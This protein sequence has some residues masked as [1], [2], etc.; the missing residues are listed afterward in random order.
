MGIHYSPRTVTDGLVLAFDTGNDKSYK[1]VPT[2]NIAP[3]ISTHG[4]SEFTLPSLPNGVRTVYSKGAVIN[5]TTDWADIMN[6]SGYSIP[7]GERLVISAWVYVPADKVNNRFNINADINGSNTGMGSWHDLAAGQWHKLIGSWLNSTGATANATATRLEPWTPAEWTGGSI[8]TYGINFMVESGPF[9][10]DYQGSQALP[11]NTTRSVSGSLLDLTGNETI[12]ISNS[13][14]T[15]DGLTAFDGTGD[16]FNLGSDQVIKT[17]GGWTVESIVKYDAVAG[18]YNNLTSPANFIGS[19]SV[20][21][22]RHYLN[23]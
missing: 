1:G 11:A 4:T 14:F 10:V 22:N 23:L 13:S 5:G 2:T 21:Y 9:A 6:T 8:T 20:S 19:D 7:A 12:N 17:S 3:Y 15:N 18:G 16:Y